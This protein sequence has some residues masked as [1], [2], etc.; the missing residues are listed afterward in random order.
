MKRLS[1]SLI[2]SI[3]D[4]SLLNHLIPSIQH[5]NSEDERDADTMEN[6]AQK[7]TGAKYSGKRQRGMFRLLSEF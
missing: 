2:L 5:G 6:D 3:S 1:L 7:S 4:W